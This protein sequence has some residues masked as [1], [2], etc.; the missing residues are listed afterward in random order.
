M[1]GT[2]QDIIRN[3]GTYAYSK[4]NKVNFEILPELYIGNM[5]NNHFC[6][7]GTDTKE[8][9]TKRNRIQH[10]D[11]FADDITYDFNERGFRDQS[12]PTNLQDSIWCVGDGHTIGMGVKSEDMYCNILENKVNQNVINVSF[13]AA[14]NIWLSCA[15]VDILTQVNP[16]TLIIGWTHFDKVIAPDEET[17]DN[18]G[19]YIYFKKCVDRV[20]KANTRTNIIHFVVPNSTK[21]VISKNLYKNFFGIIDC[22]DTGRDGFH[23]G[24]NT[25]RFLA[26]SIEDLLC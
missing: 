25:H 8:Y 5:I 23:I 1:P 7:F 12:W 20:Y 18:I 9:A 17:T 4:P 11:K 14:N 10:F 16:K 22:L 24:S 3:Q 15:A 21:H 26:K 13:Y 19:S 2:I 6:Y